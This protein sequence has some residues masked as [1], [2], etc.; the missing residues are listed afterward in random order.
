MGTV[1][2]KP[3]PGPAPALTGGVALAMLAAAFAVR[4]VAVHATRGGQRQSRSA[5]SRR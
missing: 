2:V 3:L 4:G 5:A 1:L